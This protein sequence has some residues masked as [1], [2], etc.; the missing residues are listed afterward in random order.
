MVQL[1]LLFMLIL[2]SDLLSVIVFGFSE[3]W[4]FLSPKKNR[5]LVC[6]LQTGKSS[7]ASI[8]LNQILLG[9]GSRY[10]ELEIDYKFEF[11]CI[12]CWDN[13][14]LLLNNWSHKRKHW[15]YLQDMA[16]VRIILFW[17]P[18]ICPYSFRMILEI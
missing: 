9:S 10:P 2:S 14:E 11:C 18:R 7:T 1:P 13:L 17:M 8:L 3:I 6:Y 16:I 12:A 4:I 5:V 15:I